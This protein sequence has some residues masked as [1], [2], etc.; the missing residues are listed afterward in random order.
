MKTKMNY[1]HSSLFPRVCVSTTATRR[2]LIALLCFMITLL[3]VPANAVT[4]ELVGNSESHSIEKFNSAGTWI[5]TFASTGPWKPL[6]IAASPLTNDVFVATLTSNVI[7]RYKSDGTRLVCLGGPP[8][9]CWS[10]FNLN[11]YFVGNLIESLVFDTSGNLYVASHYGTSGY[12][13]VILKFSPAALLKKMPVPTGVPITTTVGRGDQMAFDQLGNICI[14]S[15]IAPNTVQ[16]YNPTSGALTFDYASEFSGF[17][18]LIQPVGLAF[19]PSNNL[20]V[21]S[22]FVGQVVY[23]ATPH[24]GPM[25]ALASG[26]VSDVGFIAT[27]SSGMLYVPSFHNAE[28]RY[29][30]SNFCTFYSCMDYDTS[31][32]VVYKIDPTT[33]TTT[34][35]ITTNLWGPYQMIFVAF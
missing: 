32:D 17:S 29:G 4:N 3:A 18:P 11:S 15:F 24:K 27:D 16:C 20:Y 19:S 23:E 25:L 5:G 14:A 22:V 31:S 12:Q 21:S 8:T 35:F 9:P 7:L 28:G 13:V 33:G 1:N 26:L 34:D 10:T 30:G 6:G 2:I